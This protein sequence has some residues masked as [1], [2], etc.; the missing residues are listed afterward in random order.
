MLGQLVLLYLIIDELDLIKFNLLSVLLHIKVVHLSFIARSHL[1]VLVSQALFETCYNNDIQL[2]VLLLLLIA[3]SLHCLEPSLLFS[4]FFHLHVLYHGL[5]I[6]GGKV[7][8]CLAEVVNGLDSGHWDL[9][10]LSL[11]DA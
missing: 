4:F 9:S 11:K 2:L 8:F 10:A 5:P 6:W 7:K 1:S 3:E